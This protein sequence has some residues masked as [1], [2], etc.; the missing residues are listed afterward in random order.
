MLIISDQSAAVRPQ[1]A[2]W[3]KDRIHALGVTVNEFARRSQVPPNTLYDLL[4]Q[5]RGN[6]RYYQLR[7]IARV[8]G[9][10][11]EEIYAAAGCQHPDEI[12][13]LENQIETRR[14]YRS[15]ANLVDD[16]NT[17]SSDTE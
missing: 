15:L 17:R 12:T 14:A 6:I 1:F 9:M 8:L 16:V 4:K 13:R 2:E 5:R 3:L 10:S 11:D 7:S